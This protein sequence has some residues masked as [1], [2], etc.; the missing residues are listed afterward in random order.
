LL[1]SSKL[2]LIFQSRFVVGNVLAWSDN[3]EQSSEELFTEYYDDLIDIARA[4]RR[5]HKMSNTLQTDDLLHEAFLKLREKHSFE[6]H[7]HFKASVVLAMRH[8]AVD[9]ARKRLAAKRGGKDVQV[10]YEFAKDV[11]EADEQDAVLTLAIH[12]LMDE[13]A[14]QDA[15]QARIVDC[16]FFAGFSTAETAQLIRVDETTVRRD[17]KKAQSW[18][19]EKLNSEG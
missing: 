12:Q 5:Q 8:I 14:Q 2:D 11:A 19:R 18:L 7:H 13:L 10:D 6:D 1:P 3:V 15:R 17:W 4:L 9:R 16:R